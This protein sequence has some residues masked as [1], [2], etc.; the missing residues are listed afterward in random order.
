[1]KKFKIWN[2]KEHKY[3]GSYSRAYHDIYDFDSEEEALNHNCHGVFH[4]TDTY[5]IHE[6]EIAETVVSKLPPKPEHLKTTEKA[7][8]IRQEFEK[9][10]L[11][12]PDLNDF[13]ASVRIHM[14]KLAKDIEDKI[15][16][17]YPDKGEI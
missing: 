17:H 11:E 3:S 13:D 7:R 15:M 8:I 4:D 1:M 9:N 12:Y 5:E 10:R 16:G 6:I 14:K 2:K